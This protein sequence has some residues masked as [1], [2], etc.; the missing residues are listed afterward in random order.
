[1]I[2]IR[3]WRNRYK[4]RSKYSRRGYNQNS[5]QIIFGR[6]TTYYHKCGPCNRVV[7]NWTLYPNIKESGNARVKVVILR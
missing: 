1:M 3:H 6:D 2:D 7:G 5:K 4:C